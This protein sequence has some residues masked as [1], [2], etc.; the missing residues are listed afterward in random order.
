MVDWFQDHFFLLNTNFLKIYICDFEKAFDCLKLI[1]RLI[2]IS[3]I[4]EIC[5]NQGWGA[6][7]G[8]SRVFLPPWSRSRKPGA[9]AAK[10]LAGSSALR[11]DKEHKEIVLK[12]LSFR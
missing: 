1:C 6:G 9:G 7:A 10:K 2:P 11:E 4:S 3:N 12:L 5:H 8:R